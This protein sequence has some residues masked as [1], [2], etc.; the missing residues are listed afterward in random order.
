MC[1]IQ[2]I[3]WN[4]LMIYRT[5][6]LLFFV[7]LTLLLQGCLLF[8]SV[9]YEIKLDSEKSGTVTVTINDIRSTAA[10]S[11]ELNEDKDILFQF[12]E[13]SEDFISQ[14][15]D[16]G[17]NITSREYYIINENLNGTIKY[18]F[19]DITKVEAIVYD[20]PFYYLTLALED[21]VISTNGEIVYSSEHKRIIWD[22]S[23]S[24]LEFSMF[25]EETSSKKFVGMAQYYNK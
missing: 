8:R 25:G 19:D 12:L 10:N 1:S 24:T 23:M 15:K 22:N 11:K 17:K 2:Q 7:T 16:E 18:S 21:S 4:N 14:M 6:L 5:I 3:I 20:E 9:S 13:K